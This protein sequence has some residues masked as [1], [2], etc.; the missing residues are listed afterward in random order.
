[1]KTY[2]ITAI[3]VFGALLRPQSA[4]TTD[5]GVASDRSIAVVSVDQTQTTPRA[6]NASEMN[7][8]VGGNLSGCYQYKG[9]DGDTYGICCIDLWIF[10]VCASVNLSAVDRLVSSVF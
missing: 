1:M 10:A 3:L 2:I 9:A 8:V 6:L 5:Q 4:P 7:T